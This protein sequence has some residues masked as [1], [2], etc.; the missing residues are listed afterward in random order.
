ML[1][2]RWLVS[3][4]HSREEVHELTVAICARWAGLSVVLRKSAPLSSLAIQ[5]TYE[6]VWGATS[7]ARIR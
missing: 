7:S 3:L 6:P 1:A 4:V 2:E 5:K